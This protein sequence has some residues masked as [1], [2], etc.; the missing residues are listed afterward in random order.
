MLLKLRGGNADSAALIQDLGIVSFGVDF[1]DAVR[2][3]I[4][5][6]ITPPLF[7]LLQEHQDQLESGATLDVQGDLGRVINRL[8]GV[9]WIYRKQY[10]LDDRRRDKT[11]QDNPA[12]AGLVKDMFRVRD[13]VIL[14][15]SGIDHH[16]EPWFN[17][18]EHNQSDF[19]EKPHP[20]TV[21]WAL[22]GSGQEGPHLFHIRSGN[23]IPLRLPPGRTQITGHE[24][25][26]ESSNYFEYMQAVLVAQESTGKYY[27]LYGTDNKGLDSILELKMN[28]G[29]DSKWESSP[30][31]WM[32]DTGVVAYSRGHDWCDLAYN[33]GGY[34]I[35]V[36]TSPH[37]TFPNGRLLIYLPRDTACQMRSLSW[38]RGPYETDM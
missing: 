29:E 1:L 32:A 3:H 10:S 31:T 34:P 19:E 35:L 33:L 9:S 21:R 23:E 20:G 38:E 12:M 5:P 15:S 25:V 8:K 24:R 4:S 28:I 17:G 6:T 26:A 18:W 30:A 22:P 14:R 36:H 2:S 11:G 27:T 37:S 13:N 7:D 16:G